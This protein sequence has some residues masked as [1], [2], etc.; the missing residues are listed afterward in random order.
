MSDKSPLVATPVNKNDPYRLQPLV[1]TL[2][3]GGAKLPDGQDDLRWAWR[4]VLPDLRSTH[5]PGHRAIVC[6]TEQQAE[7]LRDAYGLAKH[8][9]FFPVED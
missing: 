1:A 7:Y 4:L 3:A 9:C 5:D 6:A 2:I 8:Q